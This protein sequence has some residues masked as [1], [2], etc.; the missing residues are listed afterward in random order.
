MEMNSFLG[1]HYAEKIRAG[2]AWE[3]WRL[4]V[5]GSSSKNVLAHL[6]KSIIYW[7]R[8]CKTS[9]DVIP[10]P[11]YFWHSQVSTEPPWN[12]IN[13]WNDYYWVKMH[14]RD[15]IPLFEKE[16]ELI[17]EQL[18]GS[19]EK[20]RLPLYPELEAAMYKTEPVASFDFERQWPSELCLRLPDGEVA[21]ITSDLRYVIDGKQSVLCDTRSARG[22]WHLWLHA[23]PEKIKFKT[24]QKYLIEFDYKI[25][26]LGKEKMPFAVAART[27][28]GGWQKDVG[29]YRFWTGKPGKVGHKVIT[30]EPKD[31]DDY[32]LFFCFQGKVA[33]VLDNIKIRI[34]VD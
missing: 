28:A 25:I 17:S 22:E 24:G 4:G 2:I 32:Y 31:Y 21:D 14:W 27:D 18:E 7:R 10:F 20:A 11:V 15:M 19:R 5:P 9:D 16:R 13:I 8:L 12:H 3:S 23:D 26:D 29:N 1:L 6:D 34:I 30:I 33:I